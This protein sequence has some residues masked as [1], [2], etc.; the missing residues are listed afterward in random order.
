MLEIQIKKVENIQLL[1][2]CYFMDIPGL[3]ENMTSYIEIVFS[4]ITIDGVMFEVM[5]FD[6]TSIGS[7]NIVNIFKE[8]EEKKM[9]K[10]K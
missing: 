4:L 6:S 7:D 9:F 3:N 10:K 1:E 5:V 2:Q 8:L